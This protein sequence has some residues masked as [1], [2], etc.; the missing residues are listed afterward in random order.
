[1]LE[2]AKARIDLTER[3]PV[4][5]WSELGSV[6]V[7]P[8]AVEVLK[9]RK[10]SKVY[11]LASA[12]PGGSNVI[13]KWCSQ[14]NALVER[15]IYEKV[16]SRLPFPTLRYYGLL[17]EEGSEFCWV[18]IEDA[19][20]VRYCPDIEEH[21]VLAAEWLGVLHTSGVELVAEL[22]L[23]E[24]GP[25][26]YLGGLRSA[27]ERIQRNLR[28]P[29]LSDEDRAVLAAIATQCD[30]VELR[31]SQIEEY[32]DG[33]PRTFV[34]GD[35]HGGNLRV[36]TSETGS[37]VVFFDWEGAGWA[38]P[39]VD[40][41]LAGLHIP[42]YWSV[43]R[44]SWPGVEMR[45]LR[46]LANAGKIFQLLALVDWESKALAYQWPWKLMKHMRYYGTEMS[47]AIEAARLL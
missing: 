23:T 43:V 7:M 26:H 27:R 37:A 42:T 19:G 8:E 38:V 36:R 2:H 47:H 4:W 46:R 45:S 44:K 12:G 9:D 15:T 21:C 35:C 29:D 10:D 13:A 6:C 3:P 24:M 34:H 25:G 5:A 30:I 22:G 40:L 11:R 39:A 41:A 32:C 20:G 33:I 16:L 31:W 17:E 28:S 1:M 18:F 14:A